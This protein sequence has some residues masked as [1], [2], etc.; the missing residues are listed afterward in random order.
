M[1]KLPR[2]PAGI[3]LGGYI[4]ESIPH[5]VNHIK[6]GILGFLE[7]LLIACDDGDVLAYYTHTFLDELKRQDP[8]VQAP[9]SC[10]TPFFH[11]H[12][13]SSVWG[14]A[15]RT[16]TISILLPSIVE[17]LIILYACTSDVELAHCSAYS[18]P[19]KDSRTLASV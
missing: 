1:L 10:A 4:D 5:C 7:V 15:L 6:V 3:S 14:L 8:H 17:S 18:I 12:V 11:E 16:Y 2:T 19:I 9:L 13:E